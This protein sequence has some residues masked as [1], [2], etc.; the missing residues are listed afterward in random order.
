MKP[1]GAWIGKNEMSEANSSAEE[2]NRRM[3]SVDFAWLA[4]HGFLAAT[5]RVFGKIL[6]ERI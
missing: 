5:R 1:S 2:S 6:L 4:G 3:T